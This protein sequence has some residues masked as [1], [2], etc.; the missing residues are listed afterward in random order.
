MMPRGTKIPKALMTWAALLLVS[1]VSLVLVPISGARAAHDVC[2][3][4]VQGPF[5][6]A[7]MVFPVAKVECGAVRQ[8]IHIDARLD[9]DGSLAAQA[10][11]TCRKVATC[12]LGLAS[13]GIFAHDVP[14]DQQWCGSAT[15]W[16]NNRGSRHSLDVAASC[17]TESF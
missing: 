15:G 11:R 3:L 14:G 12:W 10:S 17:E 1:V 5:V 9:M 7:N 2:R 4:T 16:V 8:T 6:Y 13:D